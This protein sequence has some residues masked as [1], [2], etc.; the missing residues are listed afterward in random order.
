MH[1]FAFC[2]LPPEEDGMLLVKG[3]NVMRGYLGQP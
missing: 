3:F 1:P 2:A